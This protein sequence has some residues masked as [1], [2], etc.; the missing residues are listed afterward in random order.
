MSTYSNNSF[1][2]N[3]TCVICNITFSM[4]HLSSLS[5]FCERPVER[6]EV[7]LSVMHFLYGPK[8]CSY[9]TLDHDVERE[10]ER[11]REREEREKTE[12]EQG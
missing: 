9:P 7:P 11:E 3:V 1:I 6:L 10:R 5:N 2:I 8:H 4:L 12:E